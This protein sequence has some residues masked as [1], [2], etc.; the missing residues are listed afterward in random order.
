MRKSTHEK[1]VIG[2]PNHKQR[3]VT[4]FL[5]TEIV[6]GRLKPGNQLPTRP[7]L[8][9]QFNVSSVT[10]QRALDQLVNEGFVSARPRLGTFVN[11]HPPHLSRY[12]IAFPRQPDSD[13]YWQYS[14]FW[15]ALAQEAAKL[16][17]ADGPRFAIYSGVNGHADSEDHI[18]LMAD[19]EA[20]RLAGVIFIDPYPY[21]ALIAQS[22]TPCV[23]F[24]HLVDLPGLLA[25]QID[26]AQII[27]RALDDL[28][29]RG[30]KRVAFLV[31]ELA[32]ESDVQHIQRAVLQRGMTTHPGWMIG[33]SLQRSRWAS[34]AAQALM[35]APADQRP[36]AIVITD[37]H[38]VIPAVEGLTQSGVVPGR[39]VGVVGYC[40]HGWSPPPSADVRL[41]GYVASDLLRQAMGLINRANLTGDAPHVVQ[42]Q[43]LFAEEARALA[44]QVELVAVR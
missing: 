14:R 35:M 2:R 27:N 41:L 25:L 29:A 40:N 3:G 17:H 44:E 19:I 8:M 31:S 34:N 6:E 15:T 37:D 32:H 30:R 10:M 26:F 12:A 18:R 43:P 42:M 9:K 23:A 11:P 1:P 22:S 28:L 16:S 20:R 13:R 33:L 38:L 24:M 39:D 7:T 5:R 4:A 36:D 21:A